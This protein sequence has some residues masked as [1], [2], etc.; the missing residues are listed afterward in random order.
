MDVARGWCRVM[1]F[2]KMSLP[3]ACALVM[4]HLDVIDASRPTRLMSA[5][6]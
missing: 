3:L 4:R 6:G 2:P 5:G 1:G